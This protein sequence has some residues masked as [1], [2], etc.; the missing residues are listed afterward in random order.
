MY[1]Q[2]ECRFGYDKFFC[3]RTIPFEQLAE[4]ISEI[5]KHILIQRNNIFSKVQNY[6]DTNLNKHKHL[7][8]YAHHR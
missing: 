4:S 3:K 2:N 1:N 8:R 6:I 5:E 7:E